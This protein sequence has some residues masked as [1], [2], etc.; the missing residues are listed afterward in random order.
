MRKFLSLATLFVSIVSLSS[1]DTT[2][3]GASPLRSPGLNSSSADH[4]AKS[5]I[6][7]NENAN[8]SLVSENENKNATPRYVF[9][10]CGTLAQYSAASWYNDLRAKVSELPLFNEYD[11]DGSGHS[12]TSDRNLTMNDISE[13]CYDQSN[14]LV[15]VMVG[16]RIFGGDGFR[17]LRFDT[18]HSEL[19]QATRDDIQG[20]TT[21]SYYLAECDKQ[22]KA[23]ALRC[24]DSY[25]WMALPQEFGK[26]EGDSILLSGQF[27]DA[28]CGFESQYRYDILSNHISILQSCSSCDQ[29]ETLCTTY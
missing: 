6:L 14:H 15:L 18:L 23:G 8:R 5:I 19:S 24:E 9:D 29:L 4:S 27:G 12:F 2:F 3:F 13:I 7:N 10:T 25:P 20:G 16:E 22:K 1:C 21:S 11:Q 17:L 26:R 28:G